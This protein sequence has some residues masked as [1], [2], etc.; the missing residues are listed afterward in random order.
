M[1]VVAGVLALLAAMVSA[2]ARASD[3]RAV[4]TVLSHN[5]LHGARG[6]GSPETVSGSS[7]AWP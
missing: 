5:V 7:A 4:L 1:R 6:Q 3:E 2:P